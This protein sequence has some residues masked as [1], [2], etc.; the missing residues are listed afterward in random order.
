VAEAKA[1]P[2]KFHLQGCHFLGD[3]IVAGRDMKMQGHRQFGLLVTSA[4]FTGKATKI[5]LIHHMGDD[6]GAG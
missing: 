4:Q 6:E 1:K 2:R 3:M 5:A